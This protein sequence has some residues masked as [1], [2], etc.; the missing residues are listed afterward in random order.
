MIFC[1]LPPKI[2]VFTTYTAVYT[3]PDPIDDELFISL[4]YRFWAK[5]R[6]IVWVKSP[7]SYIRQGSGNSSPERVCVSLT[8]HGMVLD[9]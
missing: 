9:T 3:V 4:V 2:D 5:N 1:N 7:T 6:G 8:M